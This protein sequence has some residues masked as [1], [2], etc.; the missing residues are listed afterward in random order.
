MRENLTCGWMRRGWT[1]VLYSS[2]LSPDFNRG[3]RV[4]LK[5]F[6]RQQPPESN[7]HCSYERPL[8]NRIFSS[9]YIDPVLRKIESNELIVYDVEL[10]EFI[11]RKLIRMKAVTKEKPLGEKQIEE[12]YATIKAANISDPAL[13]AEH[14]QSINRK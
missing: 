7:I 14:I 12:A 9:F 6:L 4:H 5:K 2:R 1:P 13:R 8:N 11:N 10:S 3:Q